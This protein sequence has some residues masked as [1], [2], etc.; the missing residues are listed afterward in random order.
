ML[1]RAGASSQ[2]QVELVDPSGAPW[3]VTYRCVPG[4]YSYEFRAGWRALATAWGLG[5]GDSV[6]LTRAGPDRRRLQLQVCRPPPP[7]P[8]RGGVCIARAFG[9]TPDV[10]PGDLVSP[11]HHGSLVYVVRAV[12]AHGR[13]AQIS[14][15]RVRALN[16]CTIH[17][18]MDKFLREANQADAE[19]M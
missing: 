16:M 10:S 11:K 12:D 19:G 4:R 13:P 17:L 9:A 7:P 15:R 6:T 2:V 3:P 8:S 5:A 1:G 18:A 14:R